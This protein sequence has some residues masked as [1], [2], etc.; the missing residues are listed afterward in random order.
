MVDLDVVEVSGAEEVEGSG[1]FGI[2]L[3]KLS[4]EVGVVEVEGGKLLFFCG[5]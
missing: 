3:M 1:E 2:L 4:E 5:W